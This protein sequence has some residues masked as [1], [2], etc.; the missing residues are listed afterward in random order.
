MLDFPVRLVRMSSPL[1]SPESLDEHQLASR[2]LSITV[3]Q[4]TFVGRN[5]QS[6]ISINTSRNHTKDC[7]A[8]TCEIEVPQRCRGYRLHEICAVT[9]NREL[10]SVCQGKYLCFVSATGRNSPKGT[11]VR[12]QIVNVDPIPRFG[13]VAPAVFCHLNFGT[14]CCALLPYLGTAILPSAIVDPFSVM[15][16]ARPDARPGHLRKANW[17]APLRN[18]LRKHPTFPPRNHQMQFVGHLATILDCPPLRSQMTLT[19]VSG[20]RPRSIS[21]SPHF[22]FGPI[23]KRCVCRRMN[24]PDCVRL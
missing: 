13:L 16:P 18:G 7:N 14:A 3:Q 10:C 4:P 20:S 5:G 24:R 17:F 8:S 11:A 12:F 1:S 23:R 15:R 2:K 21:K 22:R 19:E 9:S 6:T